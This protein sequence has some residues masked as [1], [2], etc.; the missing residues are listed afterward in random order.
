VIDVVAKG[1]KKAGSR[2]AGASEP[3][4]VC[5]FQLATGKKVQYVTQAQP[6]TSFPAL[7]SD[8][9]RLTYALAL[10][11]LAAAVLPHGHEASD[12]FK[13]LVT[14]LRYLEV[15]EKPLAAL[16]WAECRLMEQAGFHPEFTQCVVD[17][18]PVAEARA[19]V[20]PHAGGY[21]SLQASTRYNDRFLAPA[22]SL[23]AASRIVELE[24]PPTNLRFA[25]QT[26][27]MLV[28]FWTALADDPLPANR[29][30]SDAM[31]E[32]DLNASVNSPS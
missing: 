16:V 29:Q 10:T 22:E 11:E 15:H 5:V 25:E 18:T 30:V 7:R 27:R 24:R 12:E 19:W 3:L 8:Y 17:G 13:F 6:I 26:F 20:S 2:L 21:L 32:R 28:R 9:D 31:Q 14:A 23:Y 1:A 4:S